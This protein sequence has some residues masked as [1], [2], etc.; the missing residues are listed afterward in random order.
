MA[1][2]P[3]KPHDPGTFAHMIETTCR[4]RLQVGHTTAVTDDSNARGL[5]MPCQ[6]V[7]Y[8]IQTDWR[9]FLGFDMIACLGACNQ[10]QEALQLSCTSQTV[11]LKDV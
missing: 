7:G 10:M 9:S 1:L 8:G 2:P 4:Q 3:V 11:C 6:A 5:N